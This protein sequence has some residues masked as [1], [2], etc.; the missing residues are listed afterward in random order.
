MILR[1]FARNK[2]RVSGGHHR[3]NFI[4]THACPLL[5]GGSGQRGKKAR[6]LAFSRGE[7]NW[8]ARAYPGGL[9]SVET[10]RHSRPRKPEGYRGRLA[11]RSHETAAQGEEPER[12]AGAGTIRDRGKPL[13][14]AETGIGLTNP[15][16]WKINQPGKI[17]VTR[18][19]KKRARSRNLRNEFGRVVQ[20]QLCTTPGRGSWRAV[21]SAGAEP[22]P[23]GIV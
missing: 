14:F 13:P 19:G 7:T 18:G 15:R 8:A 17:A 3:Q 2:E 10:R 9:R 5:G 23:S 1:L 12:V 4:D 21:A 11:E 20:S 6:R 16:R 22:R